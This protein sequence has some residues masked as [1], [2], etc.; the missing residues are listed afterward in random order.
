MVL[1]LNQLRQEVPMTTGSLGCNP[2]LLQGWSIGSGWQEWTK[3]YLKK[4]EKNW[5][6]L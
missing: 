5:A 1:L 3:L 2:S 4:R 6:Q